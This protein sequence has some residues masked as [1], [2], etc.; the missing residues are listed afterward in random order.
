[1]RN[2]QKNLLL[3][4]LNE[5]NFDYAK[6]YIKK[7]NLKNLN[8]LIKLNNCQTS[9]EV[10]YELLEPWIQWVTFNTGKSATQHEIFRLGDVDNLKYE[11][12][13][14]KIEK[15]GFKVGAIC[16]MNTVNR[17][18][19]PDFFISDPWTN[20][21]GDKNYFNNLI[22]KCLSEVINNNSQKKVGLLNYL[23]ILLSTIR[24]VRFKKCLNLFKI[25]SKIFFKKW[26]R[27][28]FLEFLLH[29]IYIYNLKKNNTNFSSVFFNGAAHIQHHYFFNIENFKGEKNPEWY[30]KNDEDPFRDILIFYDEIIGDYLKLNKDFLVIT[31]LSQIPYDYKKYYYRIN[32]PNLF[33]D[34][35]KIKYK[36][37]KS[38]MTRDFLVEFDNNQDTNDA[39]KKLSSLKDHIGNKLFEKLDRRNKSIFVTL[40]YPFEIKNKFEVNY[41]NKQINLNKYISFV[42]LKN[43]MHD[44]KGFAF[45]N[46]ENFIEHNSNLEL[47]SFYNKIHK[48]FTNE[49]N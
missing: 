3:I 6:Y 26:Y 23:I 32:N 45:T 12:I 24:Y 16:P 36:R 47:K 7:Y 41:E 9:S 42:A 37:T 15:L 30:I 25:L 44:G 4:K 19:S 22:S 21:L 17:L 27:V 34:I 10:R 1:M 39:F 2:S 43:G 49:K 28:L 18:K 31:G 14:E 48:Y 13:Y 38:R 11:Q 20:T 40:T 35:L 29:E 8:K 5:L 46:I 33:L